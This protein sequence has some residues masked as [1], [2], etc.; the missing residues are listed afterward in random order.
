[1]IPSLERWPTPHEARLTLLDTN[2]VFQCLRDKDL[3]VTRA[4]INLG[5]HHLH[6][7]ILNLFWEIVS[8]F[9]FDITFHIFLLWIS[10]SGQAD[11]KQQAIFKSHFQN[12]I[13]VA[14]NSKNRS[15]L[16]KYK[17]MFIYFISDADISR[18][19]KIRF[20]YIIFFPKSFGT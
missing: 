10:L 17:H 8:H 3:D 13:M 9:F 12:S 18:K 15:K 16:T 1:M 7:Q 20:F 4:K 2:P 14:Q 6:R 11:K 19:C 5:S